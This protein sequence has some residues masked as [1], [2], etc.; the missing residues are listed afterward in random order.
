MLNTLTRRLIH[1]GKQLY[2]VA[3]YILLLNMMI[4]YDYY[5]LTVLAYTIS[6]PVTD[7]GI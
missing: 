4:T 1:A 3:T 5:T 2:M 7:F 6:C